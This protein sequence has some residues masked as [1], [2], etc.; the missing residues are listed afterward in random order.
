MTFIISETTKIYIIGVLIYAVGAVLGSEN[1]A[2]YA[3]MFYS[4]H[5]LN[6]LKIKEIKNLLGWK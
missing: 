3:A 6:E 4:I 5:R 1:L 2:L